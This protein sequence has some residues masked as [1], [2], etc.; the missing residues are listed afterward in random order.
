[1]PQDG[2]IDQEEFL[3]AREELRERTP[4]SNDGQCSQAVYGAHSRVSADE[5]FEVPE[6]VLMEIADQID[7]KIKAALSAEVALLLFGTPTDGRRA[8]DNRYTEE[9][10]LL[11]QKRQSCLPAKQSPRKQQSPRTPPVRRAKP[12]VSIKARRVASLSEADKPSS[13]P[14]QDAE[15]IPNRK[16]PVPAATVPLPCNCWCASCRNQ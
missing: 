12:G 9:L 4:P 14:F 15:P 8:Q 3:A 10:G 16:A 7:H 11:Q 13:W 2:V 1:M 5:A 6:K